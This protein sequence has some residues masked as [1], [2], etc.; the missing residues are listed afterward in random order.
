MIVWGGFGYGDILNT[1]GRYNPTDDSW[2]ATRQPMRPVREAI[3]LSF[4]LA[5][6]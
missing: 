5:V 1:G 4:G 2:T 6:K 3:T